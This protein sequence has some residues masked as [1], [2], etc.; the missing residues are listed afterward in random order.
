MAATCGKVV[1]KKWGREIWIALTE[2]YC[3]K[4]IEINKGHMT[5]LQYHEKKEET[6]F[7]ES[8]DAILWIQSEDGS[9]QKKNVSAGFFV[10]LEPGV[11]HRFEAV[12]DIVL[13]ECSNKYVDDVVRVEDNY[14][15]AEK[16]AQVA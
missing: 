16:K 12:S 3:F 14:G 10:H 4:R 8:G 7:V 6:N 2:D 5:S 1:E 13:M 11:L 15:R 9:I